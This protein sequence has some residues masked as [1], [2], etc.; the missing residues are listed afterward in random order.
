MAL[1]DAPYLVGIGRDWRGDDE[2]WG[3]SRDHPLHGR[4][5]PVY[6]SVMFFSTIQKGNSRLLNI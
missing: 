1:L 4:H 2:D 5:D 6:A 3:D